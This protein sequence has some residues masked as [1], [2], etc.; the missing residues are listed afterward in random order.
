VHAGKIGKQ[1]KKQ[2]SEPIWAQPRCQGF[3]SCLYIATNRHKM[4]AK[5]LKTAS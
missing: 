2:Q 5:I 3:R 4:Q 1:G